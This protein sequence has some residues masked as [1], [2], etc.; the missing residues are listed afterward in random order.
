MLLLHSADL[1][2]ERSIGNTAFIILFVAGLLKDW[3]NFILLE[4]LTKRAEDVLQLSV[5]DGAVFGLVVELK[6]FNEVLEGT[7][8]LVLLDGGEDGQK[9]V[10][11]YFLLTSSDIEAQLFNNGIGWVQVQGSEKISLVN[12]IDFA[13]ALRVEDGEGELYSFLVTSTDIPH[14]EFFCLAHTSTE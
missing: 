4:A 13:L 7:S 10:H 9:F 2:K 14:C 11:L 1:F 5:H 3:D 12:A 8:I 6:D